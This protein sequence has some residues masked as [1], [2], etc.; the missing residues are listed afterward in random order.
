M[1]DIIVALTIFCL[2]LAHNLLAAENEAVETV[3]DGR[4]GIS[5]TVPADWDVRKGTPPLILV[6]KSPDE[7]VTDTFNENCNIIAV[8]EGPT[9]SLEDLFHRPQPAVGCLT[10]FSAL[11]KSIVPARGGRAIRSEHRHTMQGVRLHVLQYTLL[12]GF[13]ERGTPVSLC[14]VQRWTTPFSN[15]RANSS[16]SLSRLGL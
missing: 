4:Y 6:L 3:R 8:P 5:L 10:G 1:K 11:G 9:V 14:P 16:R 7:G 12:S 2:I 13:A 15:G